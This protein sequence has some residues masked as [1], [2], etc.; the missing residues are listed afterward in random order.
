MNW[1]YFTLGWIMAYGG[2]YFL[3]V[4]IKTNMIQYKFLTGLYTIAA[5]LDFI[6]AF[7]VL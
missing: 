4:S 7:N 6:A 3:H 2:F 1:A 5:V